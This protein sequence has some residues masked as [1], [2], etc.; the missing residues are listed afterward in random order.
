MKEDDQLKREFKRMMDESFPEIPS[1]EEMVGPGTRQR[2]IDFRF[3]TKIA[4]GILLCL[5][6][7]LFLFS[8][9]APPAAE[10]SLAQWKEPTAP[11]VTPAK[12]QVSLYNWQSPTDFLLPKK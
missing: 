6:L 5:A 3:L 11:L 7:G 8:R 10:V 1:Y 12:S 2:K 9:K 4:A